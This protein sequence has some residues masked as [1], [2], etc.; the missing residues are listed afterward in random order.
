MSELEARTARRAQIAPGTAAGVTEAMIGRLV[1]AFYARVRKDPEIGPIFAAAIEDWDV[2]L[3][4]LC[5]FWSSVTLMTGRFK[6]SPMMAHARQPQIR[7]EH[8]GTWL[9][10]WRQTA[11]ELCPPAAAE[12]FIQKAEMIGESLKLGLAYSRGEPLDTP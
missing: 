9:A 8:F 1:P 5:D 3:A 2:H 4:K 7:A 12:L 10:L 6:G 11:R